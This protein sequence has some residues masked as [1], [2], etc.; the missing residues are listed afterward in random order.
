MLENYGRGCFSRNCHPWPGRASPYWLKPG[1][2]LSLTRLLQFNL[3]NSL[4]T[5]FSTFILASLVSLPLA[6]C[7][8]VLAHAYRAS[9]NQRR[10]TMSVPGGDG[11]RRLP[12]AHRREILPGAAENEAM[13]GQSHTVS[14]NIEDL[15]QRDDI[16]ARCAI[17]KTKDE[18]ND[19]LL[20][21]TFLSRPAIVANNRSP[22]PFTHFEH[23]RPP[24]SFRRV[25]TDGSQVTK[26]SS[27][28]NPPLDGL[29]ASSGRPGA[30]HNS[31]TRKHTDDVKAPCQGVPTEL[32]KNH[33]TKVLSKGK[34][35]PTGS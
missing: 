17:S 3:Y 7:L 34:Y 29:P 26:G 23:F 5:V 18:S 10:T 4:A 35:S 2:A 11:K 30:G 32:D 20:K 14:F 13:A 19:Q 22:S 9:S 28:P 21:T 8:L 16:I 31:I 25:P 15:D 24:A 12:P 1:G 27:Q 33:S 6:L